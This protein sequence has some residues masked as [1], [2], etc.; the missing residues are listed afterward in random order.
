GTRRDVVRPR[1][2]D[3]FRS[4]SR[5]PV[6]GDPLVRARLLSGADPR[7]PGRAGRRAARRAH[8]RRAH[9]TA[10]HA[11]RLARDHGPTAARRSYARDVAASHRPR[12]EAP[13]PTDYR[14]LGG[15][16]TNGGAAGRASGPRSLVAGAWRGFA[17]GMVTG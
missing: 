17:A 3:R 6:V 1:L 2:H 11:S 12:H 4:P 5:Q 9:R 15:V 10:G 8:R 14:T 7:L 13:D 16:I